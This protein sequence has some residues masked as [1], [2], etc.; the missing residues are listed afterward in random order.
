MDQRIANPKE[1]VVPSI[2]DNVINPSPP[3]RQ[4][5]VPLI[6]RCAIGLYIKKVPDAALTP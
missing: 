6:N 5:Q 2:G 4:N 3:R 1:L